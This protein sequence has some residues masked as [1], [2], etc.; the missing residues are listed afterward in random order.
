MA[1]RYQTNMHFPV[2]EAVGGC[3]RIGETHLKPGPMGVAY[4]MNYAA[5]VADQT[6][7]AF[8][9]DADADKAIEIIHKAIVALDALKEKEEKKGKRR[10]GSKTSK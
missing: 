9:S 6:R 4:L 1:Y 10:C 7:D 2:D 8:K 3:I 5:I